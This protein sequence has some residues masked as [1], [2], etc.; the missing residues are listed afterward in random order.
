MRRL[1]VFLILLTA[2]VI[3]FV[4]AIATAQPLLFQ[5]DSSE[6]YFLDEKLNSE[7]EKLAGYVGRVQKNVG[8]IKYTLEEQQKQYR[9]QQ[10]LLQELVKKSQEQKKYSDAVYEQKILARLGAPFES[11]E[12]KNV[13]I[14][15]FK[16][17]ENDYRGYIAKVKLYNPDVIDVVLAKGELGESETTLEAV[18]RELAIFGVNAGG[19]Y[20]T[21]INGEVQLLPIGNT[22]IDGKFVTGFTPSQDDLFFSG[23]TRDG[24]LIGDKYYEKEQLLSENPWEGVTFVPILLKNG[25]PQPIP[26]KWQHQKHP[27]TV[28]GQYANGDLIFI[29]IDGRQAGWSNGITL[30]EMQIKL[31]ELGVVDAYNLDGGGSSTFVYGGKILNRPSDGHPRPVATNIVIYP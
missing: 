26:E 3:G 1:I 28:L 15:L 7:V 22:M 27:R 9:E 14:K 24:K 10:K 31:L 16:I 2:P 25:Q 11:Y 4:A 18:K 21:S 8:I 30:E 17:H 19:F 6:L 29:V 12:S 13:Q 23:F 5:F 20:R